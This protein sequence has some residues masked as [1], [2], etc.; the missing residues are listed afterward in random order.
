MEPEG[1]TVNGDG[2]ERQQ[3]QLQLFYGK[4][5]NLTLVL[6]VT[7]WEVGLEDQVDTLV[8][9]MTLDAA[10]LLTIFVN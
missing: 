6:I 1:S 3:N 4:T 8:K 2:L 10:T 5:A 7:V 9:A